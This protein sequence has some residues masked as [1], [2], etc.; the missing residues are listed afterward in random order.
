MLAMVLSPDAQM[1]AQAELD[2]VVGPDRL[3]EFHDRDNLP[4]INALC[5]E[6]LRWHPLLPLGLAHCTTR[7]DIYGEYFIPKGVII[8][9]NSWW[10]TNCLVVNSPPDIFP[11]GRYFTT[12]QYMDQ[13]LMTSNRSVSSSLV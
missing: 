10:M 13:T 4:Y 1:K 12:K 8:F 7:D 2:A 9:G 11:K 5:K 6:I 3:P